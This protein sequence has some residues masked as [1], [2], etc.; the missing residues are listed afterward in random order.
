MLG[1]GISFGAPANGFMGLGD[2]FVDG[3]PY[4]LEESGWKFSQYVFQ[5]SFAATATTIVSGCVAGRFRFSSY[6]VSDPASSTAL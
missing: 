5:F 2:F 3:N 4:A 6:M 1:N